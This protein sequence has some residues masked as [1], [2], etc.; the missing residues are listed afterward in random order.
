MTYIK[1]PDLGYRSQ[2]SV[3]GRLRTS[4]QVSTGDYKQFLNWAPGQFNTV[5]I[6]G[7]TNVY[8]DGLVGGSKMSVTANLDKLMRQSY[9]WHNYFAGKPLKI[10]LTASAFH[11]ETDVIKRMGYFSTNMVSP[12]GSNIDG[13]CFENDGT[14]WYACIYRN[15]T[16]VY[17]Q[18][19]SSWTNQNLIA[20][21]TPENFGFYVIEFLYLG[22]AW[23][24]FS[25]MT[26][27]GLIEVAHYSHINIDPSTFIKSPNQPIRCEIEST[28][29]AG[30]FNHI[31]SDV[32][33]E[34]IA[35]LQGALRTYNTGTTGGLSGMSQD[36]RYCLM[37]GRIAQASRNII[38]DI[39]DLSILSQ[40]NDD[41]LIEL[42]FGGTTVGAPTWGAIPNTNMEA[43]LGSSLGAVANAVHS[44]GVSVWSSTIRADRSIDAA[45]ETARKIGHYIDGSPEEAYVCL[46]PTSSGGS[47]I[48]SVNWLEFI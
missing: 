25:I 46:T 18:P 34:G 11:L 27:H 19:K 24:R 13:L 9:Q 5:P 10:E 37:G 38:V 43:F 3:D 41:M 8:E 20:N 4:T 7:A 16:V 31:C 23:A 15:G 36:V 30:H 33:V 17:K 39:K 32:A 42:I 12:Y 14:E 1:Q 40:S 45:F 22:G 48:G 21:W 28:G 35:K 29:G 44:G 26:E 6:G 47:A 2:Q